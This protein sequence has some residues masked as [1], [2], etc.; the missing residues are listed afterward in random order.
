M[1][2]GGWVRICQPA[3]WEERDGRDVGGWGEE[4]GGMEWER[5]AYC[6]MAGLCAG[7]GVYAECGGGM[8]E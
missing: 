6:Y 3:R 8:G 7:V 5:G 2:V 1:V 4:V